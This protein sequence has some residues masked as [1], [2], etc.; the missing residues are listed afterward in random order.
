MYK[1]ENYLATNRVVNR[2][3]LAKLHTFESAARHLSFSS[4]AEEL[5]ISPSAVSH[6]INKLEE[7]LGFKLFERFHRRIEL[8]RDGRNL[9][10]VFKKSLNILNQEILEIKNQE[11]IGTLTIY[12]RPSFAQRWLVPKLGQFTKLYP[13]ITVNVLSGNE[14]IDFNKHRIDLAIYY[15]DLF[16]EKLNGEYLMSETIIPV[17]SPFYAKQNNLYDNVD[18]LYQCTLLHDNQAWGSDSNFDEWDTWATHFSLS[19]AFNDI[20]KIFFDRSDSSIIAAINHAGVA[21]GRKHLIE[22]SIQSG[23]LVAPFPRMHALCKQRY[24]ILTP[25]GK[26]NPKVDVF[27]QWLKSNASA[28]DN[29]DNYENNE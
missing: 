1:E 10:N 16:Y 29:S 5:C 27:I 14:I 7:E 25:H 24:H 17:C 15:D 21:M 8:T 19:I 3:Q 4:T 11:I 12:S 9:F 26:Y 23:Q 13:Y 28:I 18:N 20:H 6:Q 22:Q 2:Y